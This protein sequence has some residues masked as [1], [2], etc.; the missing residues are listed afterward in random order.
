LVEVETVQVE[1]MVLMPSDVNDSD[2][3][4][5]CQEECNARLLSNEAYW[6][7]TDQSNRERQ[8]CCIFLPKLC[9]RSFGSRSRCLTHQA[10][11]DKNRSAETVPPNTPATELVEWVHQDVVLSL[12]TNM[13]LNVPEMPEAYHH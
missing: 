7:S 8:R 9:S 3:W 10:G 13:K 1:G 6:R 5:C 12:N 4:P 11:G 2:H